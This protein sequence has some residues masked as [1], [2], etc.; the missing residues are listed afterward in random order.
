[1]EA[2]AAF[3]AAVQPLEPLL[4]PIA[5]AAGAALATTIRA[6]FAL[7]PFANSAMDGFALRAVDVGSAS[8]DRPVRLTLVGEAAAGHRFPAALAG[9]QTTRITTG[10]PLPA[11]ADAVLPQEEASLAG[12]ILL[13]PSPVLP[14][15]HVRPAG[16]DVQ[17][18]DEVLRAGTSLGSPQVALL[19]ALG[20]ATVPTIRRPRVAVV[21]TGD[22]LRLP[23]EARGDSGTY[24]ANLFA[25]CSQIQEAGGSP[26]PLP[27]ATDSP[28]AIHR[29][30][31]DGLDADAVVTSAGMCA[32]L[33]DHV[34]DVLRR[35]GSF[36]TGCLRVRPA[37]HV[38]LGHVAGK[39]VFA[40]PGNPTASLIAFE[41]LVRP[42]IRRMA[43]YTWLGR[44]IV[45]AALG[46]AIKTEASVTQALWVA[47]EHTGAGYRA[48]LAGR[49]GAGMLGT[50]AR[51]D[52]L[53]VVPEGVG[54]LVAGSTVYVHLMSGDRR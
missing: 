31:A 52:G 12:G 21:T 27:A 1:M 43:G 24:N 28:E 33:H 25:L 51:A 39:P 35:Q 30:L 37:R 54:D 26:I 29:T 42:A 6:P 20:Y 46:E 45:P 47:M 36:V 14:G 2:Q 22:E 7:P 16:E 34:A 10:A 8:P 48:R 44:P 41:L 11:G 23:G 32:G 18:G 19:A 40:L 49:Q 53:L 3:Q 50:A 17:A 9:G 4:L 5:A 38:G 13:V 15:R